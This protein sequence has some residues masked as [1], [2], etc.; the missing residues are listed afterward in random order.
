MCKDCRVIVFEGAGIITHLKDKKDAI[1]AR[2]GSSGDVYLIEVE[3]SDRQVEPHKDD[4]GVGIIV[5]KFHNLRE[6]S[7][8]QAE[9]LRPD[10]FYVAMECT[11]TLARV[12]TKQDAQ[13]LRE[14]N[15]YWI[16][17]P[18]E[19]L[20][21]DIMDR[22]VDKRLARAVEMAGQACA[23][24]SAYWQRNLY[25]LHISTLERK[26]DEWVRVRKPNSVDDWWAGP[27]AGKNEARNVMNSGDWL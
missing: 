5:T 11:A 6:W 4:D 27:F 23:I 17:S 10:A 2:R 14:A 15:G 1:V 3:Y 26:G 12:S 9:A 16:P 21:D 7:K 24:W 25:E 19:S 20:Y 22:P 8:Y 18:K 13:S